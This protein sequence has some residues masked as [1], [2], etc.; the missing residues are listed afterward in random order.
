M[1][2]PK[3]S[4]VQ[5]PICA[6]GLVPGWGSEVG[7]AAG[8]PS[9]APF[10][11]HWDKRVPWAPAGC[12]NPGWGRHPGSVPAVVTPHWRPPS[13][14][15]SEPVGGKD[16]QA[17]ETVLLL[18][19]KWPAGCLKR[20]PKRL[21]SNNSPNLMDRMVIRIQ[22]TPSPAVW[23]EDCTC[24]SALSVL[25]CWEEWGFRCHFCKGYS[26]RP[27]QRSKPTSLMCCNKSW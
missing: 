16:Q 23:T 20:Y 10:L 7:G 26:L 19:I 9:S 24:T 8:A 22:G 1:S 2:H 18:S 12:K 14:L 15:R 21:F 11:L 5:Q 27:L 13:F 25:V 6:R 17:T 3:A 4:Q